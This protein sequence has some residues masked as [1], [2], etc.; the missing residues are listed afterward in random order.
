MPE[1]ERGEEKGYGTTDVKGVNNSRK[2]K[3]AVSTASQR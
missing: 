3:S 2:E 1:K